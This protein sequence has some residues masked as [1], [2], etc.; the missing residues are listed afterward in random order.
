MRS[1][2]HY[3]GPVIRV[4]PEASL[5]E[6]ADKMDE[7]AVGCVVVA[8]DAGGPLGIITDR[9]LL[10]RVVVPGRDPEKLQARDVMSGDLLMARTDEPLEHLL[11]RMRERGVRRLPI[12]RDS[13]LVGLVTLDDVVADLGR[14][15]SDLREALRGE[16]LGA[17]RQAVRRRRREQM[18]E[19]L[20]TLHT[21]AAQLGDQARSWLREELES[22]R[23][24]I[25]PRR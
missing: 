3:E 19:M 2:D 18:D 20:E 16:V 24:R 5:R 10:R 11:D 23:A 15:L 21:E 17:R 9:D 13:H 22:L 1:V 25:G 7:F 12:L 8:D 4:R 14:E 6:I